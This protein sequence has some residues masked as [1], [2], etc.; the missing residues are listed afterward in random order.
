MAEMR[1]AFCS[2]CAFITNM[3]YDAARLDYSGNHEESQSYSPRFRAFAQELARRWIE[4]YELRGKTALEIGCGKGDFLASMLE[5]GI[6]HAIGV[7]PGARPGRMTGPAAGRAEWVL[8]NFTPVLGQREPDAIVCRHTLEHIHSVRAFLDDIRASIGSRPKTVVLFELPDALRILRETAFWDI[9]YE[10]CSYFTP[11]SLGRLFRASGFDIIDL[12]LGYDGQ[13]L[14]LAARPRPFNRPPAPP[15]PIE[16]DVAAVAEAVSHFE[17]GYARQMATWRQRLQDARDRGLRTVI[18]GG[19]AKGLSFLT[20]LGDID[21]VQY[22]VDVNP[23]LHGRYMAGI[24]RQVVPPAFLV[25]YRPHLVVV[26]N[27]VYT[28]EIRAMLGELGLSPTLVAL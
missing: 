10:H 18:W 23:N 19:G 7:D 3:A 9:Y 27:S 15:L 28:A 8:E 1:L 26:M 4:Q 11:G 2:Q 21:T 6:H 24:G 16:E 12:S 14:L 20:A 22:A 17:R 13:Y 25:Q 5:E